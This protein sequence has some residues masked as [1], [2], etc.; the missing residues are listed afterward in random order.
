MTA[1]VV[2]GPAGAGKS[3]LARVLAVQVRGCLLDL[4]TMTDPLLDAL[5]GG[6]GP[7]PH[8]NDHDLRAVVR[9]AR[10]ACL[11]D[12]ARAQAATGL[13]LVLAAP[14]SA[15]LAGGEEWRCLVDA[16][17]SHQVHV[18]WLTAP[19][20]VLRDR[21]LRRGDPRDRDREPLRPVVPSVEHL[22]LDATKPVAELV[23]AA[24]AHRWA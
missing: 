13:D 4:D 9:P 8:W 15:E 11:L 18:L 3:T 17:S 19:P 24:T 1:W 14:F 2:S 23:T 20:E 5:L 16:I 12:S 22:Q 21:L 10:Y 6:D 7:D